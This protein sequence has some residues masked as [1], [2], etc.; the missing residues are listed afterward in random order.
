MNLLSKFEGMVT[1][2]ILRNNTMGLD[3]VHLM[4]FNCSQFYL[5]FKSTIV[6]LYL[7]AV[8]SMVKQIMTIIA[9]VFFV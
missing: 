2:E 4:L 8:G 5:I 9:A 3:I 6:D 1:G 7:T